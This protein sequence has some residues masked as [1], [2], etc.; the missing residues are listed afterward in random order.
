MLFVFLFEGAQKAF[1][2]QRIITNLFLILMITFYY[3]IRELNEYQSQNAKKIDVKGDYFE[4]IY[5]LSD[6]HIGCKGDY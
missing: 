2:E 5:F 1:I 6:N 3:L 4:E